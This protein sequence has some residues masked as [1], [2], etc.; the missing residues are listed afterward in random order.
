MFGTS[1]TVSW[2]VESP[3]KPTGYG[4]GCKLFNF[5]IERDIVEVNPATGCGAQQRR[6]SE[7]ACFD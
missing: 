2:H 3:S 7:N 6:T 5:G 1:S 4:A